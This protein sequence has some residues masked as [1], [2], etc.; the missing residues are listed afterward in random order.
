MMLRYALLPLAVLQI[1]VPALPAL[2]SWQSSIGESPADPMLRAPE[3]P[4]GP[5][6][7]IWGVIFAFYLAFAVYAALRDS[8]LSR[9]LA[10]PLALAAIFSASWMLIV[11][12]HGQVL[13]AHPV[14]LALTASTF[15]AAFRFDQMRGLGGSPAKFIADGATGLFAGWMTL[16]TA[17][18]QT[19]FTRDLLGMANTDAV[20]W[21]LLHAL[22]IAVLGAL[23]VFARISRSPFYIIA[24]AWGL[25]G[26][27]INLWWLTGLH[28]PA[29]ITAATALALLAYRLR[30]GANGALR[31][32]T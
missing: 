13:W 29:F 28:A 18:S 3:S 17:I 15:W 27:V 11:Q 21:F 2:V 12:T 25:L 19:D 30:H 31:S 14:L 24:L 32:M 7:A 22:T 26:V 5:F 1:S 8:P 10:P 23:F 16:A 9:H 6:F 4:P 20:W